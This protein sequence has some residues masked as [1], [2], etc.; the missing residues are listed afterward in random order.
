[1]LPCNNLEY[2][3]VRTDYITTLAPTEPPVSIQP[4]TLIWTSTVE[5]ETILREVVL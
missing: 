3:S 2:L 4:T 5:F 1:M